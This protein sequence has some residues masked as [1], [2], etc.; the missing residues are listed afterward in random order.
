MNFSS[1]FF[2]LRFFVLFF[3]AETQL[4]KPFAFSLSLFLFIWLLFYFF[5]AVS[6]FFFSAF[7]W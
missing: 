4:F 5:F 2:L 3:S 7:V 6:P 1:F